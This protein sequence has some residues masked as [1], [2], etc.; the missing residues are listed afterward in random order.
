MNLEGVGDEVRCRAFP[1]TLVGPTIHWFNALP[2]GSVT[3]FADIT[4]AFLAQFT[5]R[6]AK[7][8][9]PINLLGVT[10][11][12]KK[13]TRKHLDRFNDECLEIDDLID[14]VASF[15]LT[16]GLLNEDFRKHLTT[17]PVW[18]MQEIQNVTREYIKD[19]EVSQVVAANKR[20]P[21]YNPA[22][23]PGNGERPKEHSKD[24][25][26][27]KAFK[28]FPRVVKFTNYTPLT[29]LI[30]EVYQQIADKGILSKPRQLKDIT[31]E[32]K[33]LYCDYH[34]GFG[35]KTQDCFDLK[36]ALEQAIREG[37]GTVN[38]SGD[39]RG[40][41]VKQRQE[42]EEDD[43][44]GL[45]IINVVV[46]RDVAPR[47]K[48][49]CRKDAKVL[50]VSSSSLVPPSR[51]IQP[52]SFGPEDQWFDDLPENPSIVITARVGTGLV[53]RILV[54][55][56]T[57]SNIMFCNVFDALGLRDTDLRT[58]Q[59][60]VVAL[61]DNFIK[62]DGIVS[63]PI[64]IG[65]G[66]GKRSVMAEFFVLRD[67]TAYNLILGRKTI[68][69]FR[70]VIC[71]KLLVIKFVAD[72]GSFGS[73]RGDL[74]TAVACDNANLSLRKKSKEAARVFLADLDARVDD[75]PRP[76]PEEDLEKFRVSDTEEKF[77]FA[78]RNLPHDLKEPFVEMI[79]ANGDLF[80]WTPVDMLGIDPNSCLTIWPL[81]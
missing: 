31:G 9:H 56:G 13:P 47:L 64:S 28:P 76:E 42:P 54:D 71:T 70:A 69:E 24:G 15:C 4:R 35:H 6:I 10:Q 78:N 63:L 65:A 55:T 20:Q 2:Q 75:K 21:A 50:A 41:T 19:E 30:V 67:S 7:A 48:L 66:R 43:E 39:D 80:A 27:S 74:K 51:R 61:G 36:D 26:P 58:H 23:Q 11:R 81:G 8:K 14:S 73:I 18:T 52:I 17:K 38:R 45:T 49:A 40:R 68:N 62:P 12:S 46:G 25:G 37:D 60:S 53:R 22:R 57:N 33:N 32:N 16:N 77:T 3:T 34:K 72:D 29:A 44:C 5:T 79:R 1:V 59:H